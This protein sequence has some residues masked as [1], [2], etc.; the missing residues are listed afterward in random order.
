MAAEGGRLRI[1]CGGCA[2]FLW[3]YA[4]SDFLALS[5]FGRPFPLPWAAVL[6]CVSFG[7]TSLSRGKGW[8]VLVVGSLHAV[9]FSLLFLALIHCFYG[10]PLPLFRIAWIQWFLGSERDFAGWLFFVLFTLL[11]A[12]FWAGGVRLV[13][14]RRGYAAIYGGFDIGTAMFLLLFLVRMLIRKPGGPPIPDDLSFELFFPFLVFG[15]SGIILSRSRRNAARSFLERHRGTGVALSLTVTLLALIGGFALLFLPILKRAAMAIDS[16]G[17][18]AGGI[19]TR[20]LLFLLGRKP[21]DLQYQRGGEE[22]GD[23]GLSIPVPE[24][25]ET[26]FHAILRWAFLGL[27][28]AAAAVGVIALLWVLVRW[29]LSRTAREDRGTNPPGLSALLARICR[30]LSGLLARVKALFSR[31]RMGTVEIYLALVRWGGRCG[32]ARL[33]SETPREYCRRL[34]AVCPFVRGEIELITEKFNRRWYGSD[35][36]YEDCKDRGALEDF[37]GLETALT[38]E[39]EQASAAGPTASGCREFWLT[40]EDNATLTALRRL[41]NPRFLLARLRVWLTR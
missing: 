33:P 4:W 8:R 1:L 27:G 14:R 13:T 26:L 28:I 3:R 35:R 25:G 15:I 17:R 24:G 23:A 10:I 9:S 19:L 34:A 30:G 39:D 2:S 31:K 40:E 22:L 5:L 12:L 21:A 6:F 29:L 38:G 16:A 36:C 37:D 7:L 11:G 32:V 20:I 18:F 41:R